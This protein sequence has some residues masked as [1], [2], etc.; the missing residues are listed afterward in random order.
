MESLG[1]ETFLNIGKTEI[2][3]NNNNIISSNNEIDN[4][5]SEYNNMTNME[6]QYSFDS[7]HD[8]HSNDYLFF[9][10]WR[11]A[12]IKERIVK[13][14]MIYRIV[15]KYSK[16]T[17]YSFNH[18]TLKCFKYRD[19]L[20]TMHYQINSFLYDPFELERLSR[21]EIERVVTRKR[22]ESQDYIQLHQPLIIDNLLNDEVI[23][24]EES[25]IPDT[26]T[27]LY[28]HDNS[29]IPMYFFP[30][31]IKTLIFG[32]NF[33]SQINKYVL[34]NSLTSLEFGRNYNEYLVDG[35]LPNSLKVIIF[36]KSFNKKIQLGHLPNS[37]IKIQ[38]K[39]SF[40]EIIEDFSLPSNLKALQFGFK[41][42][43]ALSKGLFANISN[44]TYLEFGKCFQQPIDPQTLPQT[45]TYLKFGSYYNQPLEIGSLPKSLKTLKLS[46]E[47]NQEI[48]DN[49]LP[50]GLTALS[51]GFHYNKPLPSTLPSS[52]TFLKLSSQ[53]NHRISNELLPEKNLR[54]LLVGDKFNH[55]ISKSNIGE[56]LETLVLGEA[57]NSSLLDVPTTLKQLTV[58]S[59]F[60]RLINPN[61]T[62]LTFLSYQ[63]TIL[64]DNNLEICSFI[65]SKNKNNKKSRKDNCLIC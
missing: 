42:N 28:F 31:S 25:N 50:V 53:F 15:Q 16:T 58:G 1:S 37:V 29:C 39:D 43:Q 48:K 45:L 36:G 55:P 59:N 6:S 5:V 51:F 44:L 4:D 12:L 30:N 11:N 21:L 49:V 9:Q 32:Y 18:D 10:I 26:V 20:E 19:Y 34:P 63:G 8:D 47:Y 41:Y 61:L 23:I 60:H 2:N 46:F 64:T 62:N 13:H 54:Y 24:D 56:S 27:K 38:F 22:Q 40:N 65:K 57:F 14:L 7:E 17:Q 3:N 52:L 33:N 35:A